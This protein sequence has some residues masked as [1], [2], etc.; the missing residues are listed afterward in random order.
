MADISE[1][2]G[3]AVIMNENVEILI[4]EDSPTQA[5]QL[6]HL[7]QKQGYRVTAAKN[8]VEAFEKIRESA[9]TLIISDIVMPEMDGYELCRSLKAD[10]RLKKIPVILLTALSD[11]W[12]VVRGLECGADNFFTKPYKKEALLS[13]IQYILVNQ[14]IRKSMPGGCDIEIFF[15]G[16]KHR[17]TSDRIQIL[18]L[19][20]SSFENAVHKSHELEKVSRELRATQDELNRLKKEMAP[21]I[22]ST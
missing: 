7:L 10:D 12:D 8:G 2:S 22:T 17:I 14:E 11:P 9:P 5:M 6:Q 15:S 21:K 18:D 4:A 13:R 19:L 20:L 1:E 16:Q 3:T